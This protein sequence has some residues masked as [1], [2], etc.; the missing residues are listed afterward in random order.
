MDA[1]PPGTCRPTRLRQVK[2]V[3]PV[4]VKVA[5]GAREPRSAHGRGLHGKGHGVIAAMAASVILV[6]ATVLIL[7]EALRFA[8][9]HLSGLPV[10][11]RARVVTLVL[12]SFAGHT[13]AVWT[14]AFAYWMLALRWRIRSFSGLPVEGFLDCLYFSVVTYTSLGFGDHVPVS[15]ARLLA[16]VEALN[17]LLLIG[18]STSFTYLY[19]ER[20]WPLHL[21]RG[22]KPR[23]RPQ[24]ASK[25][26]RDAAARAYDPDA[27]VRT[28]PVARPPPARG[29]RRMAAASAGGRASP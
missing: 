28:P 15:H 3:R 8:S 6:V 11:P 19:M 25:A 12:A 29:R 2:A 7:H 4:P 22:A 16:G 18:W 24:A 20:A 1:T 14:Y 26:G 27:G 5:S 13:A 10:P 21:G 23:H 9:A 17:G